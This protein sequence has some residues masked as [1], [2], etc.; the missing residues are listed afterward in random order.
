MHTTASDGTMSP[1]AVVNAVLLL[2][3]TTHPKLRVIAITDHDT[4]AGAFTALDYLKTYHGDAHLEIIIGAEITSADGHILALNIQNEIPKNLSAAETIAAIHE[5]RGLA[6]AAHPYAYVPFLKG[7]KGIKSLVADQIVGTEVDAIETCNANPTELLNNHLT[8]W[9]NR[10]NLHRPEVGGTDSHFYSALGRAGT[11]FPGATAED[12]L[13]AICSGSTRPV[14]SV[15]GPFALV[16]YFR[17]RWA[18]KKFCLA[19]PVLSH[20]Q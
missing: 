13:S 18:W 9:V 10:R 19:D 2:Q 20:L 7:L 5:A 8:R 16:E 6:I 14:G 3:L 1:Q 15:Y 12:L 11:L 4:R 17:S